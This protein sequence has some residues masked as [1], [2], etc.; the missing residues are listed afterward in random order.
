MAPWCEPQSSIYQDLLVLLVSMQRDGKGCVPPFTAPL[1]TFAQLLQEQPEDCV[2]PTLTLRRY[3]FINTVV[4]ID[5]IDTYESN[6]IRTTSPPFSLQFFC[7]KHMV[8]VSGGAS[9]SMIPYVTMYTHCS[10]QT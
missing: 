8:E 2:H 9:Y 1:M 4:V 7:I 3:V 5:F 6:L 10:E